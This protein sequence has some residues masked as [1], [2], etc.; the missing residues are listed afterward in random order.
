[1]EYT[2]C[3]CSQGLLSQ[4]LLRSRIEAF[5]LDIVKSEIPLQVGSIDAVLLI[6]V[7]SAIGPQHHKPVLLKILKVLRPG[8][9]LLMR[10][11][12]AGDLAGQRFANRSFSYLATLY[13]S[14]S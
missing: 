3:T 5:P 4:Y 11:Y 13:I 6:F 1:L 7:L 14:F 12:G 2:A 8:G 10:D 9:Y